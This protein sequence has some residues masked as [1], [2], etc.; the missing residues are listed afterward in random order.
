VLQVPGSSSKPSA[1]VIAAS[2]HAAAL[3]RRLEHDPTITV[4]SESESLD[5]LRPILAYA[6]AIE[7]FCLGNAIMTAP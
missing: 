7:A 1:F 2:A 4:L 6:G 3:R 5:A